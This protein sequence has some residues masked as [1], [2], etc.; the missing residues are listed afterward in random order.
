MAV[1]VGEGWT[2]RADGP[3]TSFGVEFLAIEKVISALRDKWKAARESSW[4]KDAQSW[5]N[6]V[7]ACR[8]EALLA[9]GRLQFMG[10][11]LGTE[12]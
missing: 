8:K 5:W 3:F 7:V 11:R 12:T 9:S 4:W 6:D 10:A 1:W 2:Y